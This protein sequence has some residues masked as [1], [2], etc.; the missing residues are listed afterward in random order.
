M[1]AWAGGL[2]RGLAGFGSDEPHGEA[3]RYMFRTKRGCLPV[4]DGERRP[5]GILTEADFLREFMRAGTGC[6][7]SVDEVD[8]PRPA[9]IPA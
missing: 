4:V 8:F 7:C 9:R 2:R 1:R 6:G 3:A 5:A